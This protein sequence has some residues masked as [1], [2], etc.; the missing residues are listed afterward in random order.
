MINNLS[1]GAVSPLEAFSLNSSIVRGFTAKGYGPKTDVG[2]TGAAGESMGTTAYAAISGEISFP[3]PILPETYGLRGAV[4]AD[5]AIIGPA[6][7]NPVA[8]PIEPG[9]VDQPLKGSVGAS[10]IWD[11]PFGPIR[12]DVGYAH[13]KATS[14]TR[15]FF[16]LTIQNLI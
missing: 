11:G 1:G 7:N 16:Q 2:A 3:L 12:G 8:E 14:D 4:W 13:T 6:A 10:I 15:E 5:A 9:S